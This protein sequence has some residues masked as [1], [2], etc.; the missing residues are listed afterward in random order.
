M[1]DYTDFSDMQQ[2]SELNSAHAS[3]LSMRKKAALDELH[4]TGSLRRLVGALPSEEREEDD[5]KKMKEVYL[6]EKY[7]K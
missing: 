4:I 1:N 5:W 6:M 3:P 7:G 2:E